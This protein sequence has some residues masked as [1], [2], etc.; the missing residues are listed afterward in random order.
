MWYE[1]VEIDE[2]VNSI[3]NTGTGDMLTENWKCQYYIPRHDIKGWVKRG[4]YGAQSSN[5]NS[6]DRSSSHESETRDG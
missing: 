4:T 3:H 1:V 5:G 2:C 6:R